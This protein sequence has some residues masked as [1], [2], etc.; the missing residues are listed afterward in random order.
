MIKIKLVSFQK[1]RNIH[2]EEIEKEYTKRL[3]RFA[4]VEC[5]S[6]KNWSEDKGLPDKFCKNAHVVGLY[7]EGSQYTSPMLAKRVAKL[8]NLGNSNFIFVIG[9]AE[10][11]PERVDSQI[12]EKWSLSKLTFSHQLV[13]M[14]LLEVLYRSFDILHGSRYHK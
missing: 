3:S 12:D 11:M 13:R 6:V 2:I 14:L 10:G 5:I 9:A 4:E 8:M 1:H 7:I